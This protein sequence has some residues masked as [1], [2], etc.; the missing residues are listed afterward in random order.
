MNI[1]QSDPVNM[2]YYGVYWC[3]WYFRHYEDC[4]KHPITECNFG[5]EIRK[6]EQDCTLGIVWPVRPLQVNDFL[7][8][9]QGYVWYQYDISFSKHRLV[10]PFQ[11]G[12]IG[13]NKIKYLNMIEHKQWKE[14]EKEG[15]K[16]GINTSYNKEVVPL[17]R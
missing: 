15:R 5:P 13:R 8:K 1:D 10:G 12:K 7:N 14:L 11:V 4:S 3:R 16:K 6:T 2:R 17:R 9:F